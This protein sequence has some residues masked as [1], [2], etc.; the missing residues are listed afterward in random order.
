MSFFNF[1]P[2][3]V[4]FRRWEKPALEG[5]L[6]KS[7]SH[8]REGFMLL[9]WSISW[10]HGGGKPF[11][12]LEFV[13][14]SIGCVSI[15]DRDILPAY[16]GN[17]YLDLIESPPHTRNQRR[18]S[19]LLKTFSCW[20]CNIIVVKSTHYWALEVEAHWSRFDIVWSLLY[21]PIKCSL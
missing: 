18:F 15:C 8:T 16:R 6:I 17:R 19:A 11:G 5:V 13:Q 3:Y 9:V 2:Q 4:A 7:P 20:L 12:W 21:S 10:N 1:I 14:L